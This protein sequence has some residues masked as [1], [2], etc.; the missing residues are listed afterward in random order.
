MK[1]KEGHDNT[2]ETDFV[3]VKSEILSGNRRMIQFK[4]QANGTNN[5]K[6]G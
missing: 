2:N 1:N 3:F 4:I 6:K 5:S